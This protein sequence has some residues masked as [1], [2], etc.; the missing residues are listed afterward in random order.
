MINIRTIENAI[1]A[2]FSTLSSIAVVW[3]QQD[4]PQPVR[5]YIMLNSDK[6]GKGDTIDFEVLPNVNGERTLYGNREFM[7]K[8]SCFGSPLVNA[9]Q[10]LENLVTLLQ[11]ADNLMIL[12]NADIIFLEN[13]DV[14]DAAFPESAHYVDSARVNIYF[15]SSTSHTYGGDTPSTSIIEEVNVNYTM[16]NKVG[17]INIDGG[18]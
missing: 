6:L 15:R 3:A 1:S 5:P 11:T 16:N 18:A 4:A 7:I 8:T 12:R 13:D 9:M 2:L 17:T 10:T 14:V